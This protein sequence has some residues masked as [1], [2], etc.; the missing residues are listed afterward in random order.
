MV[1][2]D[3]GERGMGLPNERRGIYPALP[4]FI[5]HPLAPCLRA[6]NC[7]LS[8]S[9]ITLVP[10]GSSWFLN[11]EASTA[12]AASIISLQE[13]A[14]KTCD[15][16]FQTSPVPTLGQCLCMANNVPESVPSPFLSLKNMMLI[17]IPNLHT[18][19]M[20]MKL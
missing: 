10:K 4:V 20:C 2:G 11:T 3:F 13:W 18:F 16:T 7:F 5:L 9:S 8:V 19:K 17:L 15:T 6:R 12:C 14:V 1:A